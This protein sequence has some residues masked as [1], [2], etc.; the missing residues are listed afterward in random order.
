MIKPVESRYKSMTLVEERDS[1][2]NKVQKKK[3]KRTELNRALDDVLSGVMLKCC[4]YKRFR[5]G[6]AGRGLDGS[7][8]QLVFEGS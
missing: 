7:P 5:G 4:T 3:K 8:Q 6:R 2:V 1:T